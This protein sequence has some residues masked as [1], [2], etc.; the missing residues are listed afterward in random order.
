VKKRGLL[1]ALVI[2]VIFGILSVYVINRFS[3]ND[4]TDSVAGDGEFSIYFENITSGGPSKDGI[5][6][7]ELPQYI[8]IQEAEEYLTD[9]DKVF[10][11]EGD[12]GV[13]IYPQKIL[14][15]HEI[16]NDNI[17]RKDISITYCPLTGS[18]IC[19]LGESGP[20][21]NNTFGTSGKLINSN[22]V[23]YDRASDSYIPQILGIGINNELEGLIIETEPIHWA[24]WEDAIAFYPEA[25]VLSTETGFIRNYDSDP[26]GS[27]N[28][29]GEN[30]YYYSG[31]P[32]FP[33]MNKNDGTFPDKKVVVGIKYLD[34]VVAVD[35]SLVEEQKFLNFDIASQKLIAF[36]DSRL[37]MVRVFRASIGNELLIFESHDQKIF[38]Q[39]GIQWFTNGI[40]EKNEELETLTYFDVMWF[41]WYAYYPDTEVIK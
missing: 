6:P 25:S 10:I 22:L 41:A 5:P 32:I 40:S 3:D 37:K 21:L 36:Y 12:E 35:P 7:I 2:V 20:F 15:W 13:F 26:Y 28:P 24:N 1:L 33:V 39:R 29:E 38:D 27:Y 19:Y 14:V 8:S 4:D 11:Y 23:M 18:A 34:Q 31:E 9:K 30:S 16:V 17:D